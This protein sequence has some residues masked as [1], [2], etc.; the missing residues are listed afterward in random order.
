M[1][2]FLSIF[3]ALAV[4]YFSTISVYSTSANKEYLL[5]KQV[6]GFLDIPGYDKWKGS[7]LVFDGYLK[8]YDEDYLHYTVKAINDSKTFGYIICDINYNVIEFSN[9]SSPFKNC[10]VGTS[11][12]TTDLNKTIP[13]YYPGVHDVDGNLQYRQSY[14]LVNNYAEGSPVIEQQEIGVDNIGLLAVPEKYKL[15]SGVPNYDYHESCIPT[16]IGNILGYWDS[17]GYPNLMIGTYTA[18]ITEISNRMGVNTSNAN[19]PK[20]VHGYCHTTDRYPTSFT[21]TNIWNPTF[22]QLKS[23][24]DAGRPT[25]VGFASGGDYGGAYMTACVGY[26]YE[27]TSST[28]YI[29]VHDGGHNPGDY[30]VKW[31]PTYNDFIG[32][33][34]P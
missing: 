26:Y 29:Y 24:I 14:S 3:L 2:R 9:S 17:H 11:T 13:F 28:K 18:M 32:K 23:E 5:Q 15:I 31:N 34:V 30:F 7:T 20:A 1:K 22:S 16:A 25:L 33:I 4:M 6:S 27:T 12:T 10:F 8:S 19:I 21:E